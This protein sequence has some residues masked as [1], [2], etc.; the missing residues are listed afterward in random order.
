MNKKKNKAK[1][2]LPFRA[3]F[4]P[5]GVRRPLGTYEAAPFV[6]RRPFPLA[7]GKY[8][9]QAVANTLLVYKERNGE[10][11]GLGEEGSRFGFGVFFFL[12]FVCL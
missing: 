1:P 5:R 2:S 7:L 9:G 6:R 11:R 4:A 8:S 3:V 10:G 12:L